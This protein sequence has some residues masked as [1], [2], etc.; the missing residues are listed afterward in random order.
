MRTDVKIGVVLS[1]VL[2]VAAGWYY[3]G[4]DTGIEPIPLIDGAEPFTPATRL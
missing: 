1:L 2:V 4:K 3:L